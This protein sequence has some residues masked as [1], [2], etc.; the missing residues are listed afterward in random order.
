MAEKLQP[1]LAQG[2][3]P[4]KPY[5]V[6]AAPDEVS[7]PSKTDSQVKVPVVSNL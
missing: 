6:K 3:P 5:L 4:T 7:L 2:F 1:M